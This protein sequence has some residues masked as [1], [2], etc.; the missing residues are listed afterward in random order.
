MDRAELRR[1]GLTLAALI[2]ALALTVPAVVAIVLWLAGPHGGVLPTGSAP[3]VLGL[4]WLSV[5][6]LPAWV[7][8]QAWRRLGPPEPPLSIS[9]GAVRRD[10]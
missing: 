9:A 4:G 3:I 10:R 8:R 6:L 1:A 5:L 2:A 7:A